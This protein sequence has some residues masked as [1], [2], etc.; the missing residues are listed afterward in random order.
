MLSSK[1]IEPDQIWNNIDITRNNVSFVVLT[2][3]WEGLY[4]YLSAEFHFISTSKMENSVSNK[5]FVLPSL[6]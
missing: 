2:H 3:I 5:G 4:D 1:S 6:S